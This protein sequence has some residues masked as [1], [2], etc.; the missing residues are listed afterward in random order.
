MPNTFCQ[1]NES[2]RKIKFGYTSCNNGC[3]YFLRLKIEASSIPHLVNTAPFSGIWNHKH[4]YVSLQL[5][6]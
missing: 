6:V 1:L 4:K 3:V 5:C 2:K